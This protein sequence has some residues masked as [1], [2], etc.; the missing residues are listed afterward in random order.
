[1]ESLERRSVWA[2]FKDAVLGRWMPPASPAEMLPHDEFVEA[3]RFGYSERLRFAETADLADPGEW[4]GDREELL[5]RAWE[6]G[7]TDPWDE[8]RAHVWRGWSAAGTGA[9]FDRSL[10]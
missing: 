1:M 6:A 3:T 7:H 8:V 9:S 10:H 2:R 5:R 4:T